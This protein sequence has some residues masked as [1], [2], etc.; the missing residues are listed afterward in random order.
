MLWSDKCKAYPERI[1]HLN[2]ALSAHCVHILLWLYALLLKVVCLNYALSWNDITSRF[3]IVYTIPWL[4]Y[5]H[6][7]VIKFT[8]QGTWNPHHRCKRTVFL[9]EFSPRRIF[10]MRYPRYW[11]FT[12]GYTIYCFLNA[13]SII[14]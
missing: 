1:W 9:K 7:S 3:K 10:S 14:I 2:Q 5:K 6:F 8:K 12:N 13:I 11:I 4:Q